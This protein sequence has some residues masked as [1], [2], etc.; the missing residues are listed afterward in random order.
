MLWKSLLLA[1]LKVEPLPAIFIIAL[2]SLVV[3]GIALTKI[4][5]G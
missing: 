2:A 5:G 3:V 1:L 4:P